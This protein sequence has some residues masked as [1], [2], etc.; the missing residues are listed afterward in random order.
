MGGSV[1]K[2]MLVEKGGHIPGKVLL[3]GDPLLQAGKQGWI[4]HLAHPESCGK[5]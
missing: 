2:S 1:G 5:I 4:V 3:Q